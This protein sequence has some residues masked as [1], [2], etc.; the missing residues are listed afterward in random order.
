DGGL[1]GF[2]KSSQWTC[3]VCT[4]RLSVSD[5]FPIGILEKVSPGFVADSGCGHWWF[6]ASLIKW[7]KSLIINPLDLLAYVVVD[8]ISEVVKMA[9]TGNWPTTLNDWLGLISNIDF[10]GMRNVIPTFGTWPNYG[11]LPVPDQMGPEAKTYLF[12]QMFLYP[13]MSRKIEGRITKEVLELRVGI[14]MFTIPVIGFPIPLWKTKIIDDDYDFTFCSG[15]LRPKEMQAPAKWESKTAHNWDGKLANNAPENLYSKEQYIKKAS[16]YYQS[17]DDF[18]ADFNDGRF[19]D[20]D[21]NFVIEGIIYIHA[22]D[23]QF[24][25]IPPGGDTLKVRG[26]GAI[27]TPGDIRI[28]GSVKHIDDPFPTVF[29]L[30]SL[31]GGIAVDGAEGA[32][33]EACLFAKERFKTN[34]KFTL[35]GNLAVDAFDKKEIGDDFFLRYKSSNCRTSLESIKF[36]SG[37]YDPRRYHVSIGKH[38]NYFKYGGIPNATP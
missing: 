24:I 31:D 18:L 12:G 22:E 29:S 33:V 30:I 13:T 17:E 15:L 23:G 7:H 26:R 34:C 32:I 14:C 10:P 27:V 38:Y 4:P 1:T 9:F 35:L 11:W 3:I 37:K 28:T 36:G 25:T 20:A 16:L 2:V 8:F 19:S 5:V 6:P 21:G